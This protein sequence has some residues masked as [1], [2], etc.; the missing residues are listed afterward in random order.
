MAEFDNV[1]GESKVTP[2]GNLVFFD[3]TSPNTAEKHPNNKYPSDKYDVTMVFDKGA[4]F[5]LLRQECERVAKQAF[6]TLDGVDLP[7]TDG[8]EKSMDCM[9]GKIVLRA[10]S[11]KQPILVD[12]NKTK[13]GTEDDIRGGMVARLIVTPMSYKSGRT[14]G[15]TILLKKAQVFLEAPYEPIGG[16]AEVDFDGEEGNTEE[17]F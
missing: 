13:L 11:K 15:V 4:D 6:K 1:F 2:K 9:K 10:K 7:F 16:G 8:D 17:A 12:D 5:T 3:F 14:K